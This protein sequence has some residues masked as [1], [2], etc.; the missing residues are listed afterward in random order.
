MASRV[1]RPSNANAHPGMIDRNTPRRNKDD[2]LA[3]R[4]AKAAEKARLAGERA[5]G[6]SKVATIERAEKRRAVNMSREGNDPMGPAL[7]ARVKTGRKR[8]EESDVIEGAVSNDWTR[9]K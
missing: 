6:I 4:Q 7:Q 3:E 5:A 9:T 8:A 1:T 2:V